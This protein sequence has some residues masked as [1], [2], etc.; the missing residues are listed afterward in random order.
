MSE[1]NIKFKPEEWNGG[2]IS[3]FATETAYNNA[4]FK[5]LPNVSKIGNNEIRYIPREEAHLPELYLYVDNINKLGGLFQEVRDLYSYRDSLYRSY[6]LNYVESLCSWCF[7]LIGQL[8]MGNNIRSLWKLC[9][10]GYSSDWSDCYYCISQDYNTIGS[11][12]K[13]DYCLADYIDSFDE[14]ATLYQVFLCNKDLGSYQST[15]IREIPA[16][17]VY[18]GSVPCIVTCMSKDQKW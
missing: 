6:S 10:K 8:K 11:G 16:S 2:Y 9:W 17:S 3:K 4:A 12:A 5:L 1:V 13:Q 15:S 14:I 7:E 18:N